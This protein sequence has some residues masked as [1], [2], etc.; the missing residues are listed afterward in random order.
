MARQ[1][2]EIIESLNATESDSVRVLIYKCKNIL[3][4][5][6]NLP[7]S[8]KKKK[9]LQEKQNIL[10]QLYDEIENYLRVKF[11]SPDLSVQMLRSECRKRINLLNNTDPSIE[12]DYDLL[13]YEFYLNNLN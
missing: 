8:Y 7:N 6:E 3:N 11:E 5:I 10:I 9:A 1:M 13:E 2:E 4:T 12:R